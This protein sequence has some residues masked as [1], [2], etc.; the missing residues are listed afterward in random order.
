MNS[1]ASKLHRRNSAMLSPTIAAY[2]FVSPLYD[3]KPKNAEK[4]EVESVATQYIGAGEDVLN[5]LASTTV[6]I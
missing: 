2:R 3:L 4:V 1:P 5:W 6:S